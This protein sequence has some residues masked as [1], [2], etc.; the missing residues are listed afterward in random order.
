[1]IDAQGAKL[2]LSNCRRGAWVKSPITGWQ[3]GQPE[4]WAGFQPM[5]HCQNRFMSAQAMISSSLAKEHR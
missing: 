1:M 5:L 2:R 3:N 4:K